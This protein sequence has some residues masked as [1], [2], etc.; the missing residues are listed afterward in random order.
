MQGSWDR[1]L[2]LLEKSS[3]TELSVRKI[4]EMSYIHAVQIQ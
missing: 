4:I 2:I 1:V 3:P